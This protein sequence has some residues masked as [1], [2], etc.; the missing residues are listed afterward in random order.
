M[1]NDNAC[2]RHAAVH[3]TDRPHTVCQ[4]SIRRLRSRPRHALLGI[5]VKETILI[6]E[7]ETLVRKTLCEILRRDGYVVQGTGTLSDAPL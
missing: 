4:L 2:G 6:L 1:F 5:A 7:P 3:R